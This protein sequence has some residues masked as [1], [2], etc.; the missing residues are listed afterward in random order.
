M[1]WFTDHPWRGEAALWLIAFAVAAAI[2][3]L[4]RKRLLL[5]I[6]CAFIWLL[7][8]ATAIPSYMPARPIAFRNACINNLREIQDA[9][10]RWAAERGK[11]ADALPTEADLYGVSGTNGFLRHRLTCPGGGTYTFGSVGENPRCSLLE[12]GHRLE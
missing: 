10:A 9:K 7:L 11:P 8:A 4:G 1:E 6:L 2:L 3:A 5:S 12:K